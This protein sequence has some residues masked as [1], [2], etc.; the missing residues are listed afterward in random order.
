MG[1]VI[2]ISKEATLIAKGDLSREIQIARED[3]LGELGTALNEMTLKIRNSVEELKEL[4]IKLDIVK[5]KKD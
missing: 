4:S 5:E 1:P 3:E 2:R